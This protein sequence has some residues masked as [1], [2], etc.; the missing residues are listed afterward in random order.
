[1]SSHENRDQ[2]SHIDINS[3]NYQP[4]DMHKQLA[5]ARAELDILRNEVHLDSSPIL[6]STSSPSQATQQ[7]DTNQ[8]KPDERESLYA[9][10][11]QLQSKLKLVLAQQQ[12]QTINATKLHKQHQ[13]T[14]FRCEGALVV[15]SRYHAGSLSLVNSSILFEPDRP[16][17]REAQRIEMD[18]DSCRLE[19]LPLIRGISG[20][21]DLSW[22]QLGSLLAHLNIHFNKRSSPSDNNVEKIVVQ[23]IGF[24]SAFQKLKVAI[25]SLQGIESKGAEVPAEE[26]TEEGDESDGKLVPR[27]SDDF[28][29][30]H[31]ARSISNRDQMGAGNNGGEVDKGRYGAPF[32]FGMSI[33]EKIR[34]SVIQ[35][36]NPNPFY[37][38][39]HKVATT[40]ENNDDHEN[41][42]DEQKLEKENYHYKDREQEGI[43]LPRLSDSS[44]VL[45]AVHFGQLRDACPNR[46]HESDFRLLYSTREHGISL[47][48]FYQ[49]CR[50]TLPTIVVIRDSEDA[51]F[52]CYASA[53]WK[54]DTKYYGTGESF[55]FRVDPENNENLQVFRWTRSNNYFQYSGVDHIGI[56]GGGHF[57]FHL[58]GEMYAGISGECE[59]FGSPCLAS[60]MDFKCVTLEMWAF[61]TRRS[62]VATTT[63]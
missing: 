53:Q 9:Q 16:S 35:S 37:A 58:S 23:F 59:T 54:P 20:G 33:V 39:S 60:S 24:R 38:E 56:G 50:K 42:I 48:T 6:N 21:D 10:I 29:Q 31:V 28:A 13:Q 1:M 44:H 11:Q 52:G 51:I 34:A 45:K 62:S 12:Q 22:A 18:L 4:Q 41:P 32:A 15:N 5:K 30:L 7:L 40:D 27:M 26:V 14:T 57:A 8:I 3:A 25:E 43:Y 2:Q 36:E 47:Q 61:E 55:V 49:R 63:S 17:N 46:F 19:L